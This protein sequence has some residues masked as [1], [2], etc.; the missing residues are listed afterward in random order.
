VEAF[1]C[2]PG[3]RDDCREISGIGKK[4]GC[5]KNTTTKWGGDWARGKGWLAREN[6]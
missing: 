6:E 1:G 4:K 2:I 5:E 3:M